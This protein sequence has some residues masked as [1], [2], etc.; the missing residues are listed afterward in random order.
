MIVCLAH[1]QIRAYMLWI[2]I[3]PDCFGLLSLRKHTSRLGEAM[4]SQEATQGQTYGS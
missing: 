2:A 1:P 4:T 3:I